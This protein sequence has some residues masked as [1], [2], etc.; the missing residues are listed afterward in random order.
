MGSIVG[1]MNNVKIFVLYLMRNINYP[2]DYVTINDVVRQTDFV[3]FLD[4]AVAFNE[5]LDGDLIRQLDVENGNPLYEVT[6]KG[7]LVADE[8][9]T[10]ILSP[11]LEKSL[12]AALQ[13]L[14]FRKRDIKFSSD[15]QIQR[16]RS[17]NVT[18]TITEKGKTI[19]QTMIN[20]DSES[21]AEQIRENFRSKPEVIYRGTVALVNGKVDYLFD[22]VTHI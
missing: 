1:N 17:V 10:D 4:F 7:M 11:I 6:E 8:L 22:P 19:Y 16:D 15:A 9:H 20:V 14:D 2:M 18:L 3:M 21:R 12:A 13:F 5:M